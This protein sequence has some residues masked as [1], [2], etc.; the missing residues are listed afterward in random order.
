MALDVI[1]VTQ[2]AVAVIERSDS[3]LQDTRTSMGCG[4]RRTCG[5]LT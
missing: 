5:A 4:L 1:G 3:G 2:V